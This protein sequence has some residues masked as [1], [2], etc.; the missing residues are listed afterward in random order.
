[1]LFRSLYN[2]VKLN[3]STKQFNQNELFI[4]F[5][6]RKIMEYNRIYNFNPGPAVMP[7]EVLEE[8]RDNFMNFNSSGMS[9]TEISH[10]SKLFESVLDD[11]IA[12]TRRLLGLGPEYHVI[13]VQGGASLQFCMI[14]MNLLHDGKTADYINTGVWATKAIQEAKNLGKSVNVAASSE[15]RNFC[16]IPKQY[17][18]TENAEYVYIT[19]NNTIKGTQ[20]QS[21]PDTGKVPIVADM[22]S[23]MLSRPV[24][25]EKFGLIYAGAQKNIGPAGVTMV[26]IRDDML[27]LVDEKLPSMLKYTSYTKNNSMY[28]TP[29]CLAIYMVGLT[30]KW[31]EEKIGGLEK[32]DSINRKKAA[33]LYDFIDSGN[34]YRGTADKDSRSL[35]NVTFRMPSEELEKEFVRTALENG[36]GGLGGHKSVGGCRASI[37]NAMPEKG[38]DE[39]VRFMKEFERTKG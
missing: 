15:D 12:R 17:N 30:L 25:V 13:F 19:T 36:F 23:D 14:P 7:L 16:Y 35:M 11:C 34:F 24:P 4:H 22:C 21:F 33:M 29:P 39:L 8:V 26:I 20:W 9:I 10:R 6:R 32:M 27:K 1:V 18:L 2:S 38:V 28:N 37:Y 3:I 31:L 5:S